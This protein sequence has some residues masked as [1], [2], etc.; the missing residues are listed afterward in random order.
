LIAYCTTRVT[1]RVSRATLTSS[2]LRPSRPG[3]TVTH[4]RR[5]SGKLTTRATMAI[6]TWYAK[7]FFSARSRT[8]FGYTKRTS[9]PASY[10]MSKVL[11]VRMFTTRPRVQTLFWWRHSTNSPMR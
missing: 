8:L 10:L 7:G 2:R 6:S 1:C 4:R 11:F 3:E 5:H 9:S